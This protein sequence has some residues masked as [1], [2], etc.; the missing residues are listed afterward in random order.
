MIVTAEAGEAI[1]TKPA[2]S[3][4]TLVTRSARLCIVILHAW[5]ARVSEHLSSESLDSRTLS[6]SHVGTTANL[7]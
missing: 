7:S 4:A 1:A 2:A 3:A 5:S 6:I